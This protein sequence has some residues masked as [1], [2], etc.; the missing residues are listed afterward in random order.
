MNIYYASGAAGAIVQREHGL[1]GKG[2]RQAV[3]IRGRAGCRKGHG[4]ARMVL[5]GESTQG[6]ERVDESG[7]AMCG[8][9]ARKVALQVRLADR[10]E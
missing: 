6:E 5:G 4:E 10:A 3:W 8:R 7:A 9:V 2:L 1:V